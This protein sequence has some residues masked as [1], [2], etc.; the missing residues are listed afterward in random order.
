MR[1]LVV[2]DHAITLRSLKNYLMAHFPGHEIKYARNGQE[3]LERVASQPP[4]VILM[5]MVMPRLDGARAT[6]E[7]K[8][9]W[10]EVKV[11][12]LLLDPHQGQKAIYCGADAYLLKEGEPGELL[13]ILKDMGL[14]VENS[15]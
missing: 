10:P 13:E 14:D 6:E 5:D 12:L 8:R 3:A 11:I 4:D 7:I 15:K 2:E 1:I 9:N